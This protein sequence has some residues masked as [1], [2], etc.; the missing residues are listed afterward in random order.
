M[1]RG[2]LYAISPSGKE[3]LLLNQASDAFHPTHWGLVV[4]V[5]DWALVGGVK[6]ISSVA[7]YIFP[8]L[9]GW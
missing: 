5:Y 8:Y 2:M 3:R 7:I 1:N 9:L 6:C 4:E